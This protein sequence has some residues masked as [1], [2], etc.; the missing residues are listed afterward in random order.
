MKK[1]VFILFLTSFKNCWSKTIDID[2]LIAKRA[3]TVLTL[4]K[5]I[6]FKFHRSSGAHL[7][8]K[9][10]A[11]WKIKDQNIDIPESTFRGKFGK[12]AWKHRFWPSVIYAFCNIFFKR[13]L[14]N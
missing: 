6:W 7:S 9:N 13:F 10:H 8:P 5:P 12:N 14:S 4:S 1:L 3:K 11:K 2:D